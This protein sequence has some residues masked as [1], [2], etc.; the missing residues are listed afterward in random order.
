MPN[1]STA[2]SYKHLVDGSGTGNVT[3]LSR[4]VGPYRNVK[5]TGQFCTSG[6]VGADVWNVQA[7]PVAPT[8]AAVVNQI[9][10]ESRQ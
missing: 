5:Y 9:V 8:L 3:E 4:D 2:A 10:A 1:Y 7:Q 6:I